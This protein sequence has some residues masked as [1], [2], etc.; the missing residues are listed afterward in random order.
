MFLYVYCYHTCYI[1][2]AFISIWVIYTDAIVN[3]AVKDN[4]DNDDDVGDMIMI[5]KCCYYVIYIVIYIYV[6]NA[7]KDLQIFSTP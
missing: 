1:V 2:L 7:L 3:D 6:T 4:N 5:I